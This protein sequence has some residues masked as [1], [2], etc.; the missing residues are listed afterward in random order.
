MKII[1]YCISS[2]T[3][4]NN[5]TNM[6]IHCCI[7]LFARSIS[8]IWPYI[9][10]KYVVG[11][12]FGLRN[13]HMV[14]AMMHAV[15]LDSL[16]MFATHK[17]HAS[18]RAVSTVFL[19]SFNGTYSRLTNSGARLLG[20]INIFLDNRFFCPKCNWTMFSEYSHT[21]IEMC[22]KQASHSFRISNQ[23]IFGWLFRLF[24]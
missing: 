9:I 24:D 18:A 15:L 21:H 3:Y 6:M 14:R 8:T 23:Y 20:E 5:T 17:T 22:W 11:P 12:F 13:Q 19:S 4:A 2:F 10:I 7:W 1:S 16:C